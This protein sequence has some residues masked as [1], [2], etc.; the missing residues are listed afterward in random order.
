MY[1]FFDV[2]FFNRKLLR[3][4]N[5]LTKS[6]NEYILNEFLNLLDVY[7]WDF[8][9]IQYNYINTHY[10]AGTAGFKKAFD[11]GIILVKNGI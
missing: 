8:C 10:L 3:L 2:N 6:I 11:N 4:K 5:L 1:G 7:N 9:Q